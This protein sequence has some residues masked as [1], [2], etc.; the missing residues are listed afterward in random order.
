MPEL[1]VGIGFPGE[2]VIVAILNYATVCRETMSAA[3]RD[4]LDTA[5]IQAIEDWQAFWRGLAK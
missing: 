5:N 1:K 3:N 2:A 4:R